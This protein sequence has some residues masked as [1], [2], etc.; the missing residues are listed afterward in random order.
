MLY[1][2]VGE[3]HGDGGCVVVVFSLV[4]RLSDRKDLLGYLWIGYCV[5]LLGKGRQSKADLPA[6]LGQ[7]VSV[8]SLSPPTGLVSLIDPL[9][10]FSSRETSM[11]PGQKKTLAKVSGRR[12]KERPVVLGVNERLPSRQPS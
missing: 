12:P 8:S 6:L 2:V 11:S 5:F 3:E 9:R 1:R 10:D 7:L 4:I